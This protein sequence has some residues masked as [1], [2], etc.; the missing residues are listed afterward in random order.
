M[1]TVESTSTVALL[2]VGGDEKGTQYL[3]VQLG[4]PVPRGYTIQGPGLQ[5]GGVSNLGQYCHVY[6]GTRDENNGFYFGYTLSITLTTGSTAL[7]LIYTIY[8]SPLHMH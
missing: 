2:V 3:G 1:E 6:R 5:V 8:T 4:H 7:S